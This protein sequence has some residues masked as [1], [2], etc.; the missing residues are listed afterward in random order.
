MTRLGE[1][2]EAVATLQGAGRELQ[3]LTAKFATH[4]D[5]CVNMHWCEPHLQFWTGGFNVCFL[6]FAVLTMPRSFMCYI[7]RAYFKG[8]MVDRF[9]R[10][11]MIEQFRNLFCFGQPIWRTD[12]A[13]AITGIAEMAKVRS[14]IS[15][16]YYL[17]GNC[18]YSD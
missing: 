9:F 17:F 7:S 11:F 4:M 8:G 6:C 12:R 5:D 10:F 18:T 2:A 3:I 13:G 15:Q 1:K 16:Q 14:S